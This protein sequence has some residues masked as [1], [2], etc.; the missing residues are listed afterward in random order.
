MRRANIPPRGGGGYGLTSPAPPLPPPPPPLPL[1]PVLQMQVYQGKRQ[2]QAVFFFTDPLDAADVSE[3]EKF[4]RYVDACQVYK[5][6]NPCTASIM[7]QHMHWHWAMRASALS[8][9]ASS[10]PPRHACNPRTVLLTCSRRMRPLLQ[11]YVQEYKH[12]LNEMDVICTLESHS[13][14]RSEGVVSNIGAVGAQQVT[15]LIS[16]GLVD[17]IVSFYDPGLQAEARELAWLSRLADLHNVCHCANYR[18]SAAALVCMQ[19]SG[20]LG[21]DP[22][23]PLHRSSKKEGIAYFLYC[24]LDLT[25]STLL[26]LPF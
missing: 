3:M 1:T 2:V 23:G 26:L 11:Q 8:A 17:V 6:T 22:F 20:A 13:V 21:L 19:H 18:S 16:L 14:L 12:L 5:A 15:D 4:R 7:L 25:V 24:I 10:R 9:A